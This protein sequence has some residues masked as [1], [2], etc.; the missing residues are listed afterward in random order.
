MRTVFARAIRLL[1]G[2]PALCL[3][4]AL[5]FGLGGAWHPIGDSF[6]AFRV[7]FAAAL[8]AIAFVGLVAGWRVR[9]ILAGAVAAWALVGP[10]MARWPGETAPFTPQLS[11]YQKNLLFFG[12]SSEPVAADAI[13]LGADVVAMQEHRPRGHVILER[14]AQTH[15]HQI[16]CMRLR[17]TGVA[18]ASRLPV[19]ETL[20]EEENGLAALKVE[21]AS[22]PVWVASLHLRWPWPLPQAAQVRRIL[23]R[24]EALDAPVIIA[25]D[26]NMT[27]WSH[28]I[29]RLTAATGT[30][31]P[32]PALA[33]YHFAGLLGVPIDH[34]LVP[35]GWGAAVERRPKLFSDHNGLFVTTGPRS[36]SG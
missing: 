20:C 32:A 16:E 28:T 36:G 21:T 9:A 15:P 7:P 19:S 27:P 33:T 5:L 24:L 31:R 17:R 4:L 22:G 29:D 25:G 18:L 34:V 3:A 11:I 10:V 1:L 14:L 35:R 6:A 30:H 12:A 8:L 2:L 23:P 13:A 26:Y